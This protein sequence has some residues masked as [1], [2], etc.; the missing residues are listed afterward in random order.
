M[1]SA[2]QPAPPRRLLPEQVEAYLRSTLQ[3]RVMIIDGAMGSMIQ[4]FRL[5]EEDFRG[6]RFKDHGHDL[7]GDN[8]LLVL[9]RPDVILSIHTQYYE[10]GADLCETNTFNSTSISQADYH[11]QAVVYELNR[12]AA[13]LC[14][15]AADSVMAK[16]P[17]RPRLVAGAIGPTNRTASIS[18]S[19][20]DPSAR[21]VTFREL[22]DAYKE[23]VRGLVD[24]GSDVLLV[25]TIFD[26]LNAKAAL[27]AIE[28]YYDESRHA[29]LPL[30]ISGTI[31]DLS[32]RTLS[33]QTTEAFYVSVAHAR[34]LSVGL[35]CALGAKEMRQFLQRLS[36]IAE[37]FVSCYPNAGLPNAMGGYDETPTDMAT[38]VRDFG[39]SGLLNFVGGCCGT[40]PAHIAAMAQ[41]M[42][43]VKPRVPRPPCPDLR[44]SGL[45]MLQITRETNFVNVG[46]RC[47]I[48]GSRAFKNMILA[49]QY[50][51]ALAVASQQVADGA[52]VID[53]NMD[54]G[55]L[56]GVAAMRKFLSIIV[57]EPSISR[58]PIMI[59]SSKFHIIEAGLQC[60]QG[61]CI[62]NSISLKGGEEEFLRQAATVKRYGAAVVVMAF[63]EQGQAADRD[64]KVRICQRAYKLLTE[65]VHF[66][67]QDIIFD[68]NILTICTGMEE[69]NNYAVDF[70]EATRIIKATCPLAKISG[71]LSNLSF[72][73]R[74]LDNIREAMHSVF[75]YHAIRAGMD[76]GIVNA[77]N[78]VIYD[79]IPKDLLQLVEDAVLNRH[80]HATENLLARAELERQKGTQKK[81]AKDT[82]VWRQAPVEERLK[83]ALING[84]VDFIDQD[85]EEARKSMDR[86]LKVIEGPLMAGMSVVGDLFGAGKMFL[87]QVIKS[88]RV[89]KKAV[90]YLI[91]FMEREKEERARQRQAAGLA[92][93]ESDSVASQY[94][95]TV[96]LATV[97]GDVHDIGKN[98]VGVVLGCN[99]F[100]VIDLGVMTPCEK[101]LQVARTERADVIGLSG[102]ITPSLDEMVYVAKEMERQGFKTPLL[103]GGAT[104][105]RAHTAV[106]ISPAYPSG[107]ALHVLDASRSVVVVSSLLDKNNSEDF[108]QENRELYEEVREEYYAGLEDRKYLAL[109]KARAQ[110]SH[111]K[112]ALARAPSAGGHAASPAAPA[113]EAHAAAHACNGHHHHPHDQHGL[114]HK[115]PER[116][117]QGPEWYTI[118]RPSFLGTK[119]LRQYPLEALVP[120]IDWNPFFQVWELR[121]KYPNRNYPKIFNDETVGAQARAV[122]EEAQAMLKSIVEKKLLEARGV[123]GFYPANAVGDDVVIYQDETRTTE[124]TRLCMLRQQA[125]K[126]DPDAPYLSLSDFVAPAATKLP[127]YVGMFAVSC[128]F[129]L[130]AM[131]AR[132]EKE[133]DDYHSIMAKALADR[134]AEAFA[135]KLHEEI[136]HTHWGYEKDKLDAEDLFRVKYKGIRPAPGYP[137]Q[138]DH[139]EKRTMWSLMRI[140]EES[141]IE[142]TETLAM[143]PA[144]SVSA[145]VFSHPQAEYFAVGKICKDQVQD[146]AARKKMPVAEV[147]KWL[148]PILAYDR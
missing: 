121:G 72:S 124:V 97:K 19:I 15:R 146:Y 118:P 55:L 70:I 11:M 100:R 126:A 5:K 101:I 117:H 76:M 71:G 122:F 13:E 56:D 86:P 67:P 80:A 83:H 34:P 9:T 82:L 49:G 93:I 142:L 99:N 46:E 91:P 79:D 60:V 119:V 103:I 66:P 123:V 32:G 133:H 85:T 115:E 74:G 138:P 57:T 129:G 10:A 106:K 88:A 139:T 6:E 7:K 62:V 64:S 132:Y 59:D 113:R 17:S 141:G 28:E 107:F 136:R 25:E 27:Y 2:S 14:R 35:N 44:L 61:K 30:M 4:T 92:A 36:N 112:W 145:L 31:T 53:V 95:G 39:E 110:P 94:Q 96:V 26:T 69:H 63:D 137:S 143:M 33:G 147:E 134:L 52:Q 130:D 51:K 131:V 43:G 116:E 120:Y 18:P 87:P 42:I 23:Q 41:A 105:S 54:E 111:V 48:A 104:T 38:I 20:N 45:E 98:I 89:M 65:R 47:N 50:E 37:C 29:R 148:S 90:A 21:N 8:D 109:V 22:V 75:L 24:G 102:L 125:E 108:R 16:D 68:P 78:L 40:T 81:D 73:F 3:E 127:D 84:I 135:E 128:G 140:F 1:A 144:A 77:G 58:V 114:E 12:A